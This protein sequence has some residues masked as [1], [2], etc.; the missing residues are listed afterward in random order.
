MF[1]QDSHELNKAIKRAG[2]LAGRG[3]DDYGDNAGQ[4]KPNKLLL[5]RHTL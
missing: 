4:R 3:H 1:K 2:G 5:M